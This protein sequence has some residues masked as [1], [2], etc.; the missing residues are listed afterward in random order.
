MSD[1]SLTLT[2]CPII[3]PLYYITLIRVLLMWR[4]RGLQV[5]MSTEA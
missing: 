1:D 3:V 4:L 5:T 2:L